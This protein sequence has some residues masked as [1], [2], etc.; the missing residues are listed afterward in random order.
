MASKE[1]PVRDLNNF[2]QEVR[3][4]ENLVPLLR[5]TSVQTGPN[6]EAKHHGTYSFRGVNVG[7]GIGNT[8]AI[9]RRGAAVQALV[10]FR[11]HGIPPDDSGDQ[12]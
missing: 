8:K 12:Q 6:N 4:P 11:T 5:F 1:D 10:Y 2:L 7:T 3:K 9:A